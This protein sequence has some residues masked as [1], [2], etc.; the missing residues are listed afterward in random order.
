MAIEKVRDLDDGAA[1]VRDTDGGQTFVL[2][3]GVYRDGM[4]RAEVDAAVAEAGEEWR[5]ERGP[6][7]EL[8]RNLEAGTPDTDHSSEP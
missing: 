2:K 5:R 1:V 6:D 3:P 8:G 7:S 4:D